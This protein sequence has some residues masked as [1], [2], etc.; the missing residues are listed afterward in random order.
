MSSQTDMKAFAARLQAQLKIQ[1]EESAS[2]ISDLEQKITDLRVE[3]H[4]SAGTHKDPASQPTA[5]TGSSDPVLRAEISQLQQV[6]A[7]KDAEIASKDAEIKRLYRKHSDLI[8]SM[9]SYKRSFIA[10]A[11]D[12]DRDME[13]T[14]AVIDD[15]HPEES[16]PKVGVTDTDRSSKPASS[17]PPKDV[18]GEGEIKL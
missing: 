12:I 18:K 6:L 13:A 15:L 16:T 14:A 3:Q 7:S 17:S 1:Q 10:M 2:R 5:L 9:K 8:K 11:R 4:L